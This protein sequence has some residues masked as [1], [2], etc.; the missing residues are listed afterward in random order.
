MSIWCLMP[1]RQLFLCRKVGNWVP[2]WDAL[3]FMGTE[4][5]V[6]IVEGRLAGELIR[7]GLGE[8][9]SHV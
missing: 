5:P 1:G 3:N 4:F 2:D 8:S 9:G 6:G 7:G